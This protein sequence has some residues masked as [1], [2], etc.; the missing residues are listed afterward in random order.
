MRILVIEDEFAA[1]KKLEVLLAP[2]GA[3]DA[4][5]N[6]LQA[7]ELYARAIRQGR[8]YGLITI[9]IALPDT[10]GLDLLKYFSSV[11]RKN[12]KLACRKIMAT[13]HGNAANVVGAA[14]LCDGFITKP[15]RKEVLAG[16]LK[17][18]GIAAAPDPSPASAA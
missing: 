11:E 10:S 8:P 6:G 5:T 15:I 18:L 9:D 2:Y 14:N 17:T 1:L 7:R 13:A 3:C 16:K 12:A 4:A